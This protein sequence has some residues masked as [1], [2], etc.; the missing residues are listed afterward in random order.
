M[1]D[2][3]LVST[4]GE[5]LNVTNAVITDRIPVSP[6]DVDLS[7]YSHLSDLPVMIPDTD[8]AGI[9]IG[10]DNS[11]ALLP[12]DVRR[13]A[14][15]EPFAVKTMLGWSINGPARGHAGAKSSL[16]V[17]SS[18]SAP[19][20]VEEVSGDAGMQMHLE[21]REMSREDAAVLR[22]WED[23]CELVD[24]HFQLP[25]PWRPEVD[26]V[27]NEHLAISRLKSLQRSLVKREIFDRY[28]EEIG[29]LIQ[30]GYA[31]PAPHLPQSDKVRYIPHHA[32]INPKK[33]GKLRVVFDCA[34]KTNGHSLNDNCFPGPDL[35]NR[36]IPVLIRFRSF[37]FACTADVEAMYY[38]VLIPEEQRDALRFLWFDTNGDITTLRMTRHLFGGVWCASS[39][40]FA[41]RKAAE[42][43]H[44]SVVDVVNSSF[45]VDDCLHSASSPQA[46]REQMLATKEM[47]A[48][49][50][51]KLTKF[52]SNCEE[53]MR[54]L[55][56]ESPVTECDFLPDDFA[57]RVLGV[58]WEVAPD[59]FSFSAPQIDRGDV[60][61]R[62]MLSFVASVF[63]PLGLI[64]PITVWG[65]VLLQR[66]AILKL[67][68]DDPAPADL[69][70]AW[71]R[72]LCIVDQVSAL[73]FPRCIQL[74]SDVCFELHHFSDASEL[75]Y[76]ACSYIRS[77]DSSGCIRVSL[78]MSRA[79]VA[80]LK[81]TTIPRLELQAA[82]L[83]V[84]NDVALR[85]A[86]A[87]QC[88]LLE[89]HFWTDSQVVLKYIANQSRRFYTF[90]A[91]R[92]SIIHAHTHVKQWFFIPG[93]ENV[94]DLITRG[95][96]IC[97][98]DHRQL[99]S[100]GP[101]FLHS[102]KSHWEVRGFDT[103][104]EPD[105]ETKAAVLFTGT[106]SHPFHALIDHYSEW[107]RLLRAIAWLTRL[108]V[109]LLQI[110]KKAVVKS[111][112]NAM[113][114]LTARE[115]NHAEVQLISYVQSCFFSREL[116]RLQA[117]KNVPADS[118]IRALDPFV[119]D[120]GLLRV[121]GR[122]R[123]CLINSCLHS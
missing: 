52:A 10:Q 35:L 28:D 98:D 69:A 3:D 30:K 73:V 95:R 84:K 46:L 101:G 42:H 48:N 76:G 92:L 121:G 91:N 29:K 100:A 6:A 1:V 106:K 79:H 102:H 66:A 113:H 99:W 51:F 103:A 7:S 27:N 4:S 44:P 17:C 38:Q 110:A 78:L 12:L 89:S 14:K 41:L 62:H 13:G 109:M 25:I 8:A 93:S 90:V 111:P 96:N 45:Y 68:W 57:T 39:T 74:S 123:C 70:D 120:D 82:V 80:P 54:A 105:G 53:L 55:P 47:L 97:E 9:L 20:V 86:L 61:R 75:A 72:W 122:L 65:R 64:S 26:L 104:F 77:V 67:G 107:V 85:E 21:K 23:Q 81:A 112:E 114:C 11:D 19:H 50:G 31:E 56:P 83:S 36:L 49:A 43:A 63:D 71:D 37:A 5:M 119:D 94:A 108:A 18:F 16:F 15:G 116:E 87:G 33:P 60:T 88:Q 115:M 58:R 2:F 118:S 34:A 117:G 59:S 24:G 32:V 40:T 22:L